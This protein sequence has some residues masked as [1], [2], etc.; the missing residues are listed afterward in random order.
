MTS[1]KKRP[2]RSEYT[3]QRY[4]ICEQCEKEFDVVENDE[5]EDSCEWHD[6]M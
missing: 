1:Y 6:G 4:E 5:E 2:S 3:R